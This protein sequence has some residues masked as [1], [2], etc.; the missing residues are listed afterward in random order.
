[1]TEVTETYGDDDESQIALMNRIEKERTEGNH[2]LVKELRKQLVP[3][4]GILMVG[5]KVFGAEFIRKMGYRTDN[6]DREYGNDWLD[7]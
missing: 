2:E 4:P 3:P 5:K 1:M 7:K 6:A